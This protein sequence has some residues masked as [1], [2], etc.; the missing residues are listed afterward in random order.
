MGAFS[1]AAPRAVCSAPPAAP[2]SC[3][4]HA[5]ARHGVLHVPRWC[6]RASIGHSA[7]GQPAAAACSTPAAPR[8][9]HAAAWRGGPVSP[10]APARRHPGRAG[11]SQL[12]MPILRRRQRHLGSAGLAAKPLFR[13]RIWLF[14]PGANPHAN[15]QLVRPSSCHVC[16]RGEIGRHAILRGSGESCA[17]SSL[18]VG[19]TRFDTAQD[20]SA[21]AVRDFAGSSGAPWPGFYRQ[22]GAHFSP[23]PMTRI[24]TTMDLQTTFPSSC[25]SWSAS[26]SASR[27]S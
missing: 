12:A 5:P 27:P 20:H 21:R 9:W 11:R 19:T 14:G 1:A 6:W 4:V 2:T 24:D 8:L 25:S 15:R 23:N 22:S 3:R 13:F 18:A 17:S 16:R 7:R 26:R 10:A